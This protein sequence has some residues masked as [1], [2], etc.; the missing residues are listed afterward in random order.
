MSTSELTGK[1]L[2]SD[3]QPRKRKPGAGRPK[4]LAG[5]TKSI[6]VSRSIPTRMISAIPELITLLDH[7]ESECAIAGEKSARHYFLKQVLDEIRALG[8]TDL[9]ISESQYRE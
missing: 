4:I 5:D 1:G 6:R 9:D 8:Y 7:W 2:K 3:G